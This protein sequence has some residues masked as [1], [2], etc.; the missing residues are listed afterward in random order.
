[1]PI[2][3]AGRLMLQLKHLLKH[4]LKPRLRKRAEAAEAQPA[5]AAAPETAE[6]AEAQWRN[7]RVT[8]PCA[9]STDSYYTLPSDDNGSSR[10]Y[11]VCCPCCKRPLDIT[12]DNSGC[13]ATC[14]CGD[15]KRAYM[16]AIWGAGQGYVLGALVLGQRLRELG[17][18]AELVLLHTDDVPSNYLYLLKEFWQLRPVDYI[19]AARSLFLSKGTNFDGVFTKLNAWAATEYTKVLLLDIDVIP[20]HS[21]DELFSL[22]TPAAMARGTNHIRHGEELNGREWFISQDDPDWPWTQSGGIN[23]GVILLQPHAGVF[24][25]MKHEVTAVL[26]PEHIPGSGPEQDYLSR[27]F[28]ATPWHHISVRF[29]FQPHHVPYALEYYLRNHA[30]LGTWLPMRLEMRPEDI[31][32]VHFSGAK[33]WDQFVPVVSK[34][35]H[36]EFMRRLFQS[37]F[38]SSNECD[39]HVQHEDNRVREVVDLAKTRLWEVLSTAERTWRQCLGRVLLALDATEAPTSPAH[40]GSSPLG[41]SLH[42]MQELRQAPNGNWYTAAQFLDYFQNYEAW[43]KAR[44]TADQQ[45][46]HLRS[47]SATYEALCRCVGHSIFAL[48]R[49][50]LP[51]CRALHQRNKPFG[52]QEQTGVDASHWLFQTLAEPS[53][54]AGTQWLIGE[55]LEVLWCKHWTP[56]TVISVHSCGLYVVR[57]EGGGPWGDTERRVPSHRL[58]KRPA[59]CEVL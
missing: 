26:H 27:F 57:Y 8:S 19:D 17:T 48:N 46:R 56:C 52:L 30:R 50:A 25:K 39:G 18:T 6:A 41:Q 11:K 54:P 51:L 31:H 36:D 33:L 40:P 32:N 4:L 59:R 28:A 2:P 44:D 34:E 10:W 42:P 14:T 58:R 47:D 43:D 16:A 12:V 7:L 24:A 55:K 15:E 13:G 9:P 23:A 20:L 29:N 21:L 3:A 45:Q 37:N 1:M 53:H 35:P 5:E 38:P 49:L 22:P